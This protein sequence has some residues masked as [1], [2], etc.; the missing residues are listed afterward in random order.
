MYPR[1]VRAH[2]NFGFDASVGDQIALGKDSRLGYTFSTTYN[3]DAEY[4]DG[5]YLAAVN[6]V[7]G[8]KAIYSPDLA[9][10]DYGDKIEGMTF[11]WGDTSW[12]YTRSV[13]SVS[14]GSFAKVAYQPGPN[15]EIALDLYHN[16]YAEDEVRRGIGE[17]SEDYPTMIY[18]NVAMLYTE[19]GL[20][21]AQLHG[22]HTI[23][24]LNDMLVEWNA[25]WSDST[26]KQP[27]FRILQS[28]Y[29]T[30]MQ[31]YSTNTL[32][33]PSRFF[34]DMDETAKSGGMDITLPFAFFGGRESSLKFGGSASHTNREY[35]ED[36]FTMYYG[37]G[38]TSVTSW[39]MMTKAASEGTVGVLK[40][41]PRSSG[42]WDVTFGWTAVETPNYVSNY[43]GTQDLSAGYVMGDI[44]A[45]KD[46]RLVAGARAERT[47]MRVTTYNYLGAIA[48]DAKINQVDVL[49]A[50]SLI[51]TLRDGMNL[52]FAY[53]RTLAR[54]TFKELTSSRLYDPFRREYYQGNP[55]LVMTGIDNCDLR[56]E[57]FMP[58]GQMLAL[59]AFYKDMSD[60]IE[61]LFKQEAAG[62]STGMS[63]V[64]PRNREKGRVQGLECEYRYEL[65]HL[66][67]WLDDFTAGG[68]ASLMNS[69]VSGASDGE[70]MPDMPLVGQSRYVLNANLTWQN[71]DYGTTATLLVN[72]VGSRLL[73][74]TQSDTLPDIYENPP[75][76][77]NLIVSKTLPHGIRLKFTATNL[78][79]SPYE[80]TLGKGSGNPVERYHR[81]RTFGLSVSRTF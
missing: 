63:I 7:G 25:G 16:Q 34:R 75:V 64:S 15:N 44:L 47:D 41:T 9:Q 61:V 28:L 54:P 67:S 49:P 8:I 42:G 5:G 60:P 73:E 14:W 2:P 38:G 58:K 22:K 51:Y 56:W 71:F 78:L 24:A 18:E 29:D 39:E 59:S 32:F 33:P 50:A 66:T 6:P 76:T 10:L 72:K 3:R 48:D 62:A 65:G 80:A 12:G 27:D 30:D 20:S 4:F 70:A 57:W 69:K 77:L 37:K 36:E 43:D 23:S 19:R 53:G 52:R 68:N 21:S 79:D 74:V 35:E 40:T 11:P 1:S 55:D 46:L 17:E 13:Q 81:G 45:L 31:G 26:Q